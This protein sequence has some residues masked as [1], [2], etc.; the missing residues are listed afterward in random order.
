MEAIMCQK[1]ACLLGILLLTLAG[2][3]SGGCGKGNDGKPA[4][5]AGPAAGDK[6]Q[7]PKEPESKK[8]DF[9][10]TAEAFVK[11]FLTKP[12]EAKKKYEGKVV[13]LTGEVMDI[14]D[15][16][17]GKEVLVS[18]RGAKKAPKD[19]VDVFPQ[20]V[21]LPK[22]N[23]RGLRLSP[24]QKV[25]ITGRNANFFSFFINLQDC[26]LKELSKSEVPEFRAEDLVKEVA[27]DPTA[28][29][30]KYRHKWVIVCGEVEDLTKNKNGFNHAKLKGDGK[31]RVSVTIGA[32]AL[33]RLHKGQS[34]CLRGNAT[35]GLE[36]AN[37]EVS[38]QMGMIVEA[39]K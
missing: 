22:Y 2:L 25:Q 39:K 24:K 5:D 29:S 28:A 4:Q 21:L 30:E 14:N 12:E 15:R 8:P 36:I 31:V 1:S 37:N 9:S 16:L 23:A 35:I 13:E 3:V 19:I 38:L 6:G 7:G 32:D 18:L 34:V 20:C 11:E 27:K 10:V 33:S 17:D 26:S